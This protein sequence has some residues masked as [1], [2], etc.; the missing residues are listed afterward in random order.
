MVLDSPT[1]KTYALTFICNV[2]VLAPVDAGLADRSHQRR[3]GGLV[4]APAG[5]RKCRWNPDHP[6]A[7]AASQC[8]RRND[9]V[10]TLALPPQLRPL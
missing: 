9:P 2:L 1:K 8:R 7:P 5:S 6:G 4:D 3:R 10:G